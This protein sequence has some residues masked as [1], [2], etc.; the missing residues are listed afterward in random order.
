MLDGLIVAHA[1]AAPLVLLMPSPTA[2]MMEQGLMT[3]T[4]FMSWERNSRKNS[5]VTA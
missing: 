2:A 4:L 5:S 3:S 1:P